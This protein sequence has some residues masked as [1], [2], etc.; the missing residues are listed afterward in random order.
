MTSSGLPDMHIVI[1]GT[2]LEVELKAPKG[3][4]S[5]L[6]KRMVK[7]IIDSN[8]IGAVMYEHKKD[9]PNDGYPYYI[10]YEEFKETV[11]HYANKS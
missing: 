1:N 6:Q 7:Q 5:D 10:C 3:K 8:C 11:V 2:S 4:A 9:I